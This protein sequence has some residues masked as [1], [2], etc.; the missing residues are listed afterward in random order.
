MLRA[1]L[2]AL[3]CSFFRSCMN[4][5][6]KGLFGAL[7][8]VFSGKSTEIWGSAVLSGG[9]R[10][11][12]FRVRVGSGGSYRSRSMR[13]LRIAYAYAFAFCYALSQFVTLCHTETRR[14][15]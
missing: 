2:S 9:F 6:L 5:P 11:V 15:F 13:P 7:Y 4:C 14:E 12:V 3:S 1:S 10:T 8:G